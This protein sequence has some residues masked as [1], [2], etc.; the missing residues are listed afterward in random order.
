MIKES[1]HQEDVTIINIYTSTS[2]HPKHETNNDR[3]E[4]RNTQQH[5]LSDRRSV[6]KRGLEHHCRQNGPKRHIQNITPNSSRIQ[7][8][9]KHTFSR[10]DDI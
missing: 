4:G 2:K 8:L 7:I 6:R 3:T 10:A 5:K 1:I 9:L